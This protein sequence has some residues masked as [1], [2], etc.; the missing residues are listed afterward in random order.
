MLGHKK[1]IYLSLPACSLNLEYPPPPA[2]R[3]NPP[4]P[5]TLSLNSLLGRRVVGWGEWWA[6]RS[7]AVGSCVSVCASW[8]PCPGGELGL[9]FVAV[10]LFLKWLRIPGS[11]ARACVSS[12]IPAS[13]SEGMRVEGVHFW[14]F[15]FPGHLLGHKRISVQCS[16]PH[17]GRWDPAPLFGT[18][19]R[20]V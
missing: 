2:T 13:A 4:K 1:I 18:P 19:G 16:L 20:F 11:D 6:L 12:R 7:W 9:D 15:Q 3:K 14:V 8:G 10:L 5:Q 17:P